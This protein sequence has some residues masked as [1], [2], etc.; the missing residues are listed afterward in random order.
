M[1]I[2]EIFYSIQGEGKN[3]GI[4][5]IF[6]RTT[7]CNLRC[8][9][10][11]TK[12]AYV[13]G[14]EKKLLSILKDLKKYNSKNVSITG[15]E[16]LLQKDLKDLLKI[17]IQNK[18]NTTIETNG[19]LDISD[20]INYSNLIIS[21]DI[22]CPSSN[23]SKNMILKNISYLQE[24]DQLK[25]IIKNKTDYEYAKKIIKSYKIK[26]PIFLQPVWGTNPKKLANW[27]L[28]DN[29]NVILSLQLHKL[30]WGLKKGF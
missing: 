24:K 16:P 8:S 4:P 5:T 7:G 30:I 20:L 17:L 25:M 19:S 1:K 18:Y 9:Y 10:C 2:N 13:N 15:G 29:L 26:C 6:I 11:D 28:E 3:S 27:I 21:L 12:Y 22:K 23:M 14:D